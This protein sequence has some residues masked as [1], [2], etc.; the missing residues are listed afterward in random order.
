MRVLWVFDHLSEQHA[1]VASSLA[2]RSD[3]KLKVMCRWD[4]KP[5]LD[6]SRIP[7]FPLHCRS[8]IDF[9]AR[10][11]IRDQVTMGNYDVVHAYT[12][13]NL[14]NVIGACR[15]VSDCPKIIGYRGT[16]SRLR[17][18]D[19]ANWIT[20]WHPR[21][22]KIVCVSKA[23]RRAL[24]D[25]RVPERKLAVSVEGY[26]HDTSTAVTQQALD[27][28]NIP[29]GSF[30]VGSIANMRA[31][32][33]LDLLLEAAI[34]LREVTDIYWLLIGDVRDSRITKL[35][36]DPRIADRVRLAGSI[37]NAGR[38]ASLFDIFASPSRM[39]GLGMAVIEAMAHRVCPLVSDAGGLPELVEHETSGLVVPVEDVPALAGAIRRLHDDEPLR[40]RLANAAYQ[41]AVSEF[42]IEA[43]ATRWHDIYKDVVADGPFPVKASTVRKGS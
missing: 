34:E 5:P 38:Y 2:N 7:L 35:A 18:F 12:S 33:G 4:T 30:V 16:V 40:S 21:V 3:I 8:K 13:K 42:S 15:G 36:N 20:A 26:H 43:W 23:V 10:K 41:R 17:L 28:F 14:A 37:P 19:P 9:A 27:S 22:S 29:T 31:V 11:Q 25:S 39:E 6:S 24:H 32:K 1:S